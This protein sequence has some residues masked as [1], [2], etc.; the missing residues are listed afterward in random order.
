MVFDRSSYIPED[1]EN[2]INKMLTSIVNSIECDDEC[3]KK[4]RLQ[5]AEKLWEVQNQRVKEIENSYNKALYGL[6]EAKNDIDPK[7]YPS[8]CDYKIKRVGNLE[9][10]KLEEY[11]SIYKPKKVLLDS[12]ITNYNVLYDYYFKLDFLNSTYAHEVK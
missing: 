1:K 3:E 6:I 8:V 5:K 7:K 2:E 11:K 10:K 4:K 9:S 12:I